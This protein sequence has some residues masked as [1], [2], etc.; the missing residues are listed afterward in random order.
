MSY[1][2]GPAAHSYDGEWYRL[3]RTLQG[4]LVDPD[5]RK[6]S[7]ERLLIDADTIGQVHA[8][9]AGRKVVL[10]TRAWRA[11]DV[12]DAPREVSVSYDGEPD[13][14]PVVLDAAAL[15]AD[16][17]R[18]FLLGPLHFIGSEPQLETLSPVRLNGRTVDRLRVRT[19]PGLGASGRDDHVLY[20]DREE[21][22][23]RRIRFSLGGLAS[24]RGAI[25]ETDLSDYIERDGLRVPTRFFERVRRPI[26]LLKAHRWRLTG[27]DLN[28]GTTRE[29]VSATGFTGSARRP[30]TPL[31]RPVD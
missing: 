5:Y 19:E 16:A 13:D 12:P 31:D 17:Y 10:R 7:E 9:P 2:A 22:L 3:I 4:A 29:E 18:M 30:A 1:R 27:L 23:T 15:V 20:I 11:G 24:T 25:V 21:R 6:A 26:P 14:T 8:G 28:R